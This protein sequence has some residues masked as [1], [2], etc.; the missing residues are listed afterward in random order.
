MKSKRVLSLMMAAALMTGSAG[1]ALYAT[2][3]SAVAASAKLEAPTGLKYTALTEKSVKLSWNAVG[4]AKMYAVY[5]YDSKS[6][7]YKVYKKVNTTSCEVTGL[8]ASTSYKFRVA[9]IKYS[10][11]KAHRAD[12]D[13]PAVRKDEGQV[14]QH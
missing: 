4:N 3:I 10:G 9:A 2:D 14:G 1:T 8:K 12:Q 7:K 6:G 11:G 5:K 13:G